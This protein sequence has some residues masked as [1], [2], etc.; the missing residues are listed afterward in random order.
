MAIPLIGISAAAA[1]L[2]PRLGDAVCGRG[3]RPL[4]VVAADEAGGDVIVADGAGGIAI[5]PTSGRLCLDFSS[6]GIDF[7]AGVII[8][9]SRGAAPAGDSIASAALIGLAARVATRDVG[10]LIAGPTGTGKEVIARFIHTRSPRAAGPFV[11]VN[12]A[13]IP[14]TMLEATL[15][16]FERGAFTGATGSAPGLFRAAAK[17]TLLLDEVGELPLSLQAKLLR[18]LQEHEVLPVGATVPVA[19]D[20]RIIATAN[21]DLATEVAGGR[22]RAD[23]FY[24][25]AVFPLATISLAARRADIVPITAALW[26]R[27]G[28]AAWPTSAALAKLAAHS[29]PGNVRELG[30]VVSRA[31]IFAEGATVGPDDIV[32]DLPHAMAASLVQTVRAHEQAMIDSTLTACDGRRSVA[33]RRL[34]I[35]ERTLRYKLAAMHR[36][37]GTVTL[38]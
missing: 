11:A 22:F 23:L 18:A 35:S 12:C 16:G 14:E 3:E 21:R 28:I 30:N 29:W 2:H 5:C 27:Q 33:A 32:F 34:G 38:Q 7:A 10:V 20:A 13:A 4:R 17:G 31:A 36:S 25:L 26:L 19:I 6:D 1:R 37:P 24:R 15:F 9:H 8:A